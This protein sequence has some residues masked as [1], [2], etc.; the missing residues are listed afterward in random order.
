MTM[1]MTTMTMTMTT[2]CHLPCAPYIPPPTSVPATHPHAATLPSPWSNL[3]KSG[4]KRAV[5]TP[6]V[7]LA[8]TPLQRA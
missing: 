2:C 5:E 7:K 1:T 8:L 3:R 6:V 4:G